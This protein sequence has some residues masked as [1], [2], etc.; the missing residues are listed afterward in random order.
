M[1]HPIGLEP[2][3]RVA[4]NTSG[5]VWPDPVLGHGAYY[6]GIV[7]N[8][9]NR[10]DQLTVYCA[11]DPLVA[12]TEG[13]FYQALRCQNDIASYRLKSVSYPLRSQHLL[14]AFRLD[15]QPPVIDMESPLASNLFAYAPH[16]LLNPSRNYSGTQAIADYVRDYIPPAGSGQLRPEGLKAPSVRTP[17]DG[18]F[19]PHQLALFVRDMPNSLPFD[20]RAQ[21]VAKMRIEFEF[22]THL[23][24]QLRRL[25]ARADRLGYT[26]FSSDHDSGGA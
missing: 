1:Y 13:A 4:S 25:P 2:L 14:W 3:F 12:I 26:E 9:Y 5:D 18:G 20:R 24:V 21:L 19:Q 10:P 22:F 17:F 23:P 6:V 11:Q 16:L 8:R 7:G 15:P